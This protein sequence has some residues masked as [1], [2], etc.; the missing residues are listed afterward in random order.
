MSTAVARSSSWPRATRRRSWR[1]VDAVSAGFRITPD[2]DVVF[3]DMNPLPTLDPEATLGYSAAE[4]FASIL[5]GVE[6][7]EQLIQGRVLVR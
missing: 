1:A 4:L 7:D 3:I 6:P 2:G 5:A